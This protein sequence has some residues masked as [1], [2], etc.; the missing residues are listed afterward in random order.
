MSWWQ[1]PAP[2][3]NHR[4]PTAGL[5]KGES[6]N[7][8]G[9]SH[10]E[11]VNSPQFIADCVRWW[12]HGVAN[13]ISLSP[14]A[15]SFA[16]ARDKRRLSGLINSRRDEI[17]V[18][19]FGSRRTPQKPLRLGYRC[20]ARPFRLII[21]ARLVEFLFYLCARAHNSRPRPH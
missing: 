1:L 17:S 20:C 13:L 16:N 5:S 7:L 19:I 2:A 14:G 10:A 18:F 3:A 4:L 8:G 6:S 21:S 11:I 12:K 15:F 9:N